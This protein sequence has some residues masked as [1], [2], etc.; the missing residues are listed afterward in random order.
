MLKAWNTGHPGGIATVHANSARSALDRLEQLAEDLLVLARA[1]RGPVAVHRERVDLLEFCRDCAEPYQSGERRVAVVAEDVPVEFDPLR[2]R[3]AVRNLLDNAFRH[4]AG[5]DVLLTAR[6]GPGGEV[7]ITVS[8]S[9]PGL[10][11]RLL[12]RLPGPDSVSDGLGFALVTA[13]V[14]AHGGWAEADRSG[15]GGAQVDL[16]VAQPG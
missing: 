13:I 10:P 12:G 15:T 16:V 3:Q 5:R 8:D 11:P 14:E 4:G 9:G 6:R 2:L 1:R 7:R